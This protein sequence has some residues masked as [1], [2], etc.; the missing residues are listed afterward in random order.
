MEDQLNDSDLPEIKRRQVQTELLEIK[1]LLDRNEEIL[2][3]LHKQNSHSF[4]LA[5]MIMFLCFLV[6]GIYVMMYNIPKN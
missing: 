5:V 3:K 2:S 6:Y 1:K 4:V